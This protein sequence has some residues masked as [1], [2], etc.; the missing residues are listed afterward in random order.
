[1][2]DYSTDIAVTELTTR[3]SDKAGRLFEMVGALM[4]EHTNSDELRAHIEVL[5]PYATQ[6]DIAVAQFNVARRVPAWIN[7]STLQQRVIACLPSMVEL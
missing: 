3:F 6:V 5:Y 1:V 7:A 2:R 4:N